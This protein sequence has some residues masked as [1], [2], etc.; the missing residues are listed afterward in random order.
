MTFEL[1]GGL[2]LDADSRSDLDD[3]VGGL[4]DCRFLAVNDALTL[5][6]KARLADTRYWMDHYR[7]LSQA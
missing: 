2:L 5:T 7:R 3:P 4:S 6:D 1:H